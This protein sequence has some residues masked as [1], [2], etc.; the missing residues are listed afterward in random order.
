VID[1]SDNAIQK[2]E[3]FPL[4]R[5]LTTLL[6]S[7]NYLKS[8]GDGLGNSLPNLEYLILTNNRI[9]NLADLDALEELSNLRILSLI[10]N[11]VVNKNH[12]RSY[13]INKLPKLRVLDY[14]KISDKER[15]E[16]RELFGGETGEQLKSEIAKTKALVTGNINKGVF[17]PEQ[18]ALIEKAISNVGSMQEAQRLEQIIQSGKIPPNLLEKLGIVV[19]ENEME[20]NNT[21]NE[22]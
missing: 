6:I 9:S 5:R 22:D 19:E 21:N 17:S 18:E 15:Q 16:A 14:R 4:L 12:Y 20:T 11:P 2:L 1:L 10:R 3:G 13:V 7:N 8:I